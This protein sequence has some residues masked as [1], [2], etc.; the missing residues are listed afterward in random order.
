[1]LLPASIPALIRQ[2]SLALLIVCGV[3]ASGAR[4]S[5]VQSSADVS[6][7]WSG[8]WDGSGTGDFELTLEKTKDG[9]VGGRVAVTSDGG[10]YTADLK[11]VALDG[12]KLTATYDFPLDPSAEVAVSGSFDDRTAKGTW[13]L[14]P[15]GQTTEIASGGWTVAK[16]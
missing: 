1:M 2:L 13:M 3:A 12:G 10:N 14:R 7:T 15:K 5:A 9:A 11:S 6:G 4:T 8:T 16:K